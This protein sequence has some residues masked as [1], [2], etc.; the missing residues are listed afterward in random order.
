M[1]FLFFLI[2]TFASVVG[3]LAPG[4]SN[5]AVIK[6]TVNEDIKQALKIGYG[7]GIG[8]VLL[9]FLALS[10]GMVVQDFFIM[11]LWVQ[12][13][14][15]FVLIVVGLFLIRSKPKEAKE[16]NSSF[17][18]KYVTGFLLSVINPPVLIYWVVVFSMLHKSYSISDMSATP[19]LVLFFSGVFLGKVLTLYGYGR[20]GYLIQ[21]RKSNFKCFVN[22]LVG[23]MLIIIGLIQG[24]KLLLF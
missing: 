14:L 24:A 15:V 21:N 3:A 10:F 9:A 5:L 8:E 17:S 16:H 22:R 13:L 20:L 4:A 1:I 6:T 7:A 11:N 23:V 2:G 12:F 18:S 19:V